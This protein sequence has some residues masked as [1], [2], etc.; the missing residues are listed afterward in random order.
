MGLVFVAAAHF[1]AGVARDRL[2]FKGVIKS[3][4]SPGRRRSTAQRAGIGGS[5]HD[6]LPGFTRLHSGLRE[7]GLNKAL[8]EFLLNVPIGNNPTLVALT[9]LRADI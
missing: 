1:A 8:G 7:V 4:T 3:I 5:V 6:N 9:P 2:R